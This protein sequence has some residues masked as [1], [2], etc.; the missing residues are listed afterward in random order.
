MNATLWHQIHELADEGLGIRRIAQRLRV[1]R[2]TVRAALKTTR[3]GSPQRPKR[4]S[5]IDPYRGW[6]LA[7]LEQYPELT[8]TRLFRMLSERGYGGGYSTVKNCV[9]EL[10]PRLKAAYFTLAFP[11]GD[12]AQVDWGSWGGVDV[13]GGRR[14]VSFFVMVLCHSRMMYAELFLGQAMEHWLAAHR[15]AFAAFGGVP[16]RVMVDNCKTAVLTPRTGGELPVFNPAYLDFAAHYRFTPVA[17]NPGRPNEKGRVEHAVGYLKRSFFAG[18]Q[19]TAPAALAPALADWLDTVANVRLHGTTGRIPAELFDEVERAALHPLPAGPHECAVHQP[20]VANNR[21]R[22]TTDTNR[23]S[24]PSRYASQRLALRRYADRIAVY[25]PAGTLV[26]DHPR[27]YGRGQDILV[28]DHETELKLRTRH[29]RDRRML[30]RFLSLGTAAD[31]YLTA[32]Q[33]KRPDWR[34]HVRRINALAEAH[35]RDR[36]ARLLMDAHEHNAFSS[37]YV[38]NILEARERA[39]PEPGPLHVTRRGDLLELDLPGPD[40]DI[41]RETPRHEEPPT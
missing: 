40:L 36:V 24:V 1:H 18:R 39:R 13:P 29:A 32:L 26:A 33:E 37:E 31:A 22:V 35:G 38:L 6:L 9:A 5:I 11:P 8:A 19:P 25:T 10:R 7:K 23:Y 2:R 14:A 28:P 30:E 17:C 41:Y 4:G 21:F 20:V 12:C 27:N 16:R 3:P 34:G 15:N